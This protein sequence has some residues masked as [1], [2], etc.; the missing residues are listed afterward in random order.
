MTKTTPEK[1]EAEPASARELGPVAGGSRLM[2]PLYLLAGFA[3]T[4][5]GI[6]GAFLPLMPT[7]IFLILAAWCFARSSPR[8]ER[9]LLEG[10]RIGPAI[11]AWRDEK[12]ISRRSKMLAVSGMGIGFV[13]F[14]LGA[15]PGPWLMLGVG[16]MLAACAAYVL[17][18]PEPRA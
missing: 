9:R 7:T 8:L 4:G 13:L 15:R 14:L 16:L 5:L 3:L 6:I 10:R 18:R 1:G 17:S 2:R 12:A 11:I